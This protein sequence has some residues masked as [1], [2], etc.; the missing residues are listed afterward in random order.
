VV[1]EG[2][3]EFSGDHEDFFEIWSGLVM[4][5]H[6]ARCWDD[7]I[8]SGSLPSHHLEGAYHIDIITANSY[9][10]ILGVYKNIVPTYSSYLR[11]F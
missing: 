1:S 11:F 2:T 6:L 5:S 4:G 3:S 7:D 10:R 8:I 9:A